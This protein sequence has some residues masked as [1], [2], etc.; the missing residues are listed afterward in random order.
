MLIKLYLIVILPCL[1]FLGI[2]RLN[3]L[4]FTRSSKLEMFTA[5]SSMRVFRQVNKT[6]LISSFQKVAF[7]MLLFVLTKYLLMTNL[8]FNLTS[9]WLLPLKRL[10]TLR[11]LISVDPHGSLLLAVFDLITCQTCSSL[12]T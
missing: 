4:V 7:P 2:L 3:L 10:L 8:L 12:M 9:I 5:F 11:F 1:P 6:P